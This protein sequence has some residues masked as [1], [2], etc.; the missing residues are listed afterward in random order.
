[1]PTNNFDEVVQNVL[2]LFKNI[3]VATYVRSLI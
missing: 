1:M 3:E 2:R